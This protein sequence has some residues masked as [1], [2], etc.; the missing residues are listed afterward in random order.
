VKA[1]LALA[2]AINVAATMIA[3]RHPQLAAPAALDMTVTVTAL[4]YWLIVR[5]GLRPRKSLLFV[6]LLGLLRAS[7][8]FP[9]LVPGREFIAAALELLVM[10]TLAKVF[11]SAGDDPVSGI[12]TSLAGIVPFGTAGRALA[13]ELSVLYYAFAWRAKSHVPAGARP[14]TMHKTSGIADLMLVIAP[15]SLLEIF[16][17]HLLAAHWSRPLAWILTGFSLYGALWIFA[18]GRSFAL[19]P[20]F[21]TESEILVRFGLAFSLRIPKDCIETVQREPI[22]D[23]MRVPRNSVPNVYIRFKQP[24]D[25]ERM[26]GFKKSVSAIAL[27]VDGPLPVFLP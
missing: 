24:L 14:F 25:A 23:A 4:Y 18:L 27:C 21:V 5:P 7:F 6:A 11:L 3:S 20:G 1:F 2:L 9:H 8:A 22:A 13:G 15:F 10:G 12:Q 26:L 16:P 17:V 19:R